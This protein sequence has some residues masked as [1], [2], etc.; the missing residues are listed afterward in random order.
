MGAYPSDEHGQLICPFNAVK[1]TVIVKAG[2]VSRSKYWV[3]CSTMPALEE[4][5]TPNDVGDACCREEIL[6]VE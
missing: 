2:R 1:K 5:N 3:Y 6:Y 4:L